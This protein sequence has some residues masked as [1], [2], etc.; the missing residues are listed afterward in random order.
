MVNKDDQSDSLNED[1]SLVW[2]VTGRTDSGPKIW[3][4]INSKGHCSETSF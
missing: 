1:S 3:N 4:V 2:R